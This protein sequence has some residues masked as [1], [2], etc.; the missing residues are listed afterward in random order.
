VATVIDLHFHLLSGIDDGPDAV[1]QSMMLAR[2]AVQAGTRTVVA[3]P[4][5]SWRY[6]N[7]A[8]VIA[9]GV[10][11]LRALAAAESLE[12]EILAGAEIALT[13]IGDIPPEELPRLSL[14][15]AGWL[16]VEPPFT[17]AATGIDRMIVALQHAGHRIL[18]AHPER[19]PAFHRDRPMLERLVAGGVLTSITA[20]SLVGRFGERAQA[21]A[22]ALLADGLAHNVASDA[23]DLSGRAPGTGDGIEQAGFGPLSEW[24]T[25]QV[26]HAILAGAQSVPA[27][28]RVELPASGPARRR[29]RR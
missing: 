28:P 29:R 16:L 26:P 11:E 3:T 25:E 1:E 18:L 20:G 13:R 22:F 14:G 24:L 19:C 21:F 12:L 9:A 17:P 15:G 2:A 8:D 10:A 7:T 6:P 23:H 5:V 4:H 27:R